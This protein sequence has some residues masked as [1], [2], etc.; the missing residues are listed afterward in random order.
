MDTLNIILYSI[1]PSILYTLII[2]LVLPKDSFN[3]KT[4]LV[5]WLGGITSVF[6]VIFFYNHV[7]YW[8]TLT[9]KYNPITEKILNY[10]LK[11]FIQIG[12]VEEVSKLLIFALYI[13]FG[14]FLKFFKNRNPLA[15]M[16]YIGFI[17]LGFS[18][19]ENIYYGLFST[20][21][22]YVLKIRMIT[23]VPAHLVFG[24]YMGYFVSKGLMYDK[25]MIKSKID[26]ILTKYRKMRVL[27]FS[28][29]GL[30]VSSI[31]HGIYNLHI[32]LNNDSSISGLYIFLFISTFGLYWCYKDLQ[33]ISS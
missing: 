33:Q 30:I 16:F 11:Y 28:I 3:L 32:A 21:P 6:M 13:I 31:L 18:C 17:G 7:P 27:I 29:F 19:M 8:S 4:S 9:D 24:L 10:H 26:D 5:Y 1:L 12:F 23:S 2:L 20:N 14:Y 25:I 22:L 15:I